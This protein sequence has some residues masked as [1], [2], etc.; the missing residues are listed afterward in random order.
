MD[1]LSGSVRPQAAALQLPHTEDAALGKAVLD[2]LA[3]LSAE[4]AA[5]VATILAEQDEFERIWIPLVECLSE[6]RFGRRPLGKA[7]KELLQNGLLFERMLVRSCKLCAPRLD[8]CLPMKVKNVSLCADKWSLLAG[9]S[10]ENAAS[11]TAA[12]GGKQR[13]GDSLRRKVRPMYP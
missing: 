4:P 7:L 5:V 2:L 3:R 9:A 10:P 11:S 8:T 1:R 6:D 12:T 13:H